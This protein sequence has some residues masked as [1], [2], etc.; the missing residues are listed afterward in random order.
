MRYSIRRETKPGTQL[1][2][3]AIELCQS[4]SLCISE[5]LAKL[6]ARTLWQGYQLY[7]FEL[8]DSL[9]CLIFGPR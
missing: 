4:H 5:D 3:G 8:G 6:L 7:V 2:D 1:F 9:P